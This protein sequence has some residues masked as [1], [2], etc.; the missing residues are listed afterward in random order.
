MSLSPFKGLET[1]WL[2]TC[3]R[4]YA[5]LNDINFKGATCID[6]AK[7]L[8]V[9]HVQ[10]LTSLMCRLIRNRADVLDAGQLM[11]L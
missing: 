7:P 11:Q 8:S 5:W 1:I 10:Y 2:F 6:T 3:I 4:N 9:L